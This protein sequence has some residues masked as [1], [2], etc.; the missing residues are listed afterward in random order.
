MSDPR[1]S[2]MTKELPIAHGSADF[3]CGQY[4]QKAVYAILESERILRQE[5]AAEL[6]DVANLYR[7]E[8]ARRI[9]AEARANEAEKDAARYRFLRPII[10][11]QVGNYPDGFQGI[12]AELMPGELDSF[13]DA[14]LSQETVK[15]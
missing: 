1:H 7:D 14:A 11:G 9:R 3:E 6:S 13:I 8:I 15:P 10:Q 2:K 5:I 12:W 4:D